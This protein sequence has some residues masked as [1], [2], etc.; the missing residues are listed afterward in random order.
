MKISLS[1][2]K[3][4]VDIE[5][6]TEELAERLTLAGMEVEA[7]DYIGLP[8]SALPWDPDKVVV[9]EV[10]GV[11]QHPGADRLVLADVDYGGTETELKN[12]F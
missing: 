10:L 4:Y 8:G 9:G 5:L 3:D 2:L 12:R 6:P 11:R 1:W 7:I